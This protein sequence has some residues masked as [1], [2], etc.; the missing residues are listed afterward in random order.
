MNEHAAYHTM[1][2][3]AHV[4]SLLRH[5]VLASVLF[6]GLCLMRFEDFQSC[7][8]RADVSNKQC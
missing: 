4:N 3:Y 1:L 8:T 2:C 7:C 6:L 5:N